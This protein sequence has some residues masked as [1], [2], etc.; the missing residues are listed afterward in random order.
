LSLGRY[1]DELLSD[2][3]DWT[4]TSFYRCTRS[5][6]TLGS[7]WQCQVGISDSSSNE[8]FKFTT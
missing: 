4:K 6:K 1:W 5:Q 2:R 7:T 3:T 8:I